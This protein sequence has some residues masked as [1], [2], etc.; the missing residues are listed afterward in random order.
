MRSVKVMILRG[1]H[2]GIAEKVTTWKTWK[3]LLVSSLKASEKKK[4]KASEDKPGEG[5]YLSL[6]ASNKQ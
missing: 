5:R 1:Q 4:K 3:K 6:S 2:C